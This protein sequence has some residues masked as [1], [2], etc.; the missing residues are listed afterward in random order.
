[1][2]ID[3]SG[4]TPGEEHGFTSGIPSWNL[5]RPFRWLQP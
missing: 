5:L 2:T 3:V 4:F 1:M